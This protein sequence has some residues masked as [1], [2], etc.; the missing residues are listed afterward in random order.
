MS[1]LP[2]DQALE[3]R[4]PDRVD[5]RGAVRLVVPRASPGSAVVHRARHV[6]ETVWVRSLRARAVALLEPIVH[7]DREVADVAERGGNAL[8]R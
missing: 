3:V 2:Y 7:A 8:Q 4:E 5:H 1:K 6:G